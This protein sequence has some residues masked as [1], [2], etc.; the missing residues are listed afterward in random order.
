MS[1]P[2]KTPRIIDYVHEYFSFRAPLFYVKYWIVNFT[3]QP[4]WFT[5]T[6]TKKSL[7]NCMI[8]RKNA[9]N[10]Y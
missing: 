6:S 3:T 4:S 9:I 8:H 2:K 7:E 5:Y 10:I 1:K